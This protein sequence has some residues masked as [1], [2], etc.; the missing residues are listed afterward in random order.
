MGALY[1]ARDYLCPRGLAVAFKTLVSPVCKYGS[2][3]IM[4]ASATHLSKLD[5]IQKM[6]EKLSEYT[7][8]SLHSCH[9][10]SAV[11]LLC[12]LFHF[13]GR[14]PLQDFCPTF[15]TAPLTHYLRS[16]NDDSL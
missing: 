6:A 7:F 16:L 8:P 3:A 14:G 13:R 10:A 11:G 1:H 15:A 5:T 2:V 12:K 4:G 9:E